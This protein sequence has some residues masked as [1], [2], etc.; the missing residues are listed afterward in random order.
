MKYKTYTRQDLANVAEYLTK[1]FGFEFE[2]IT[3]VY[4]SGE[5]I[6]TM[7]GIQIFTGRKKD[8]MQIPLSIEKIEENGYMI[9]LLK[10]INFR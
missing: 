6:L 7:D 5:K 1:K 10:E 3:S 9:E 4:S 2:V 8:I